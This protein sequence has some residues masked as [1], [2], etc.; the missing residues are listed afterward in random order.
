MKTQNDVHIMRTKVSD[1]WNP[2]W[3]EGWK[4]LFHK[5]VLNNLKDKSNIYLSSSESGV[6]STAGSTGFSEAGRVAVKSP[7]TGLAVLLDTQA[8]AIWPASFRAG[9][10]S[11]GACKDDTNTNL[12]FNSSK[13][14]SMQ[15]SIKRLLNNDKNKTVTGF[16]NTLYGDNVLH[17]VSRI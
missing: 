6:P 2:W 4:I 10:G 8:W 7:Q 1:F 5:L 17:T 16:G 12:H 14:R 15:K 9:H 13:Q 3:E 11:C